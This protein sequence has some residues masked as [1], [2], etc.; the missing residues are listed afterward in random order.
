MGAKPQRG[1]GEPSPLI[2]TKMQKAVPKRFSTPRAH[3]NAEGSPLG[4]EWQ[5]NR[6]GDIECRGRVV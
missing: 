1:S 5:N 2:E 4:P 6:D 3:H